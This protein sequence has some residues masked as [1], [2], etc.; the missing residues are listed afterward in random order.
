MSTFG[1]SEVLR[2]L[3]VCFFIMKQTRD[4]AIY[5]VLGIIK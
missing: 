4:N 3:N 5:N 2:V 1:V